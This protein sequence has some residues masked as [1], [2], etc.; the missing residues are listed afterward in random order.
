MIPT[1]PHYRVKR[2]MPPP[3]GPP[4]AAPGKAPGGGPPKGK[5]FNWFRLPPPTMPAHLNR[6]HH[7]VVA[8]AD[9]LK[10][11]WA[12]LGQNRT[13][14]LSPSVTEG[15]YCECVYQVEETEPNWSRCVWGNDSPR[16]QGQG[17]GNRLASR[18]PGG[19]H[20]YMYSDAEP[21]R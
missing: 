12:L 1:E 2:Q 8:M 10:A 15:P 13:T 14:L 5:D 6:S 11:D 7:S 18:Y 9:P 20:E 4:E 16:R 17:D 3:K 21:G 19:R